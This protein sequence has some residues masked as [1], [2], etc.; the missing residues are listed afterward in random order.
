[1]SAG[2]QEILAAAK[3]ARRRR[4]LTAGAVTAVVAAAVVV[5]GLTM[6]HAARTETE[7]RAIEVHRSGLLPRHSG[8]RDGAVVA[9]GDP[10]APVVVDIYADPLCPVCVKLHN[11]QAPRIERVVNEGRV[12][13]RYHLVPLLAG[14]SDPPGYSLDAGS[15]ALCAADAGVFGSYQ[16]SLFADPPKEGA[17]GYDREQLVGLGVALGATGPDFAACVREGRHHR[18]LDDALRAAQ[19]DPAL[20]APGGAFGTPTVLVD[21]RM[22]DIGNDG[23][24][25]HVRG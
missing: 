9:V 3:R 25:R 7:G 23:W 4:R 18:A 12:L 20:R 21:G 16:A 5:A 11:D 10:A 22:A 19:A 14:A 8:V 6:A 1:M 24:L 17:R 2:G 13:V 15:A